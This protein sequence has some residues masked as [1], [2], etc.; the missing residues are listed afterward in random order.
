MAKKLR[1][2]SDPALAKPHEAGAVV[3]LTQTLLH[4][5]FGA[6]HYLSPKMHPYHLKEANI[7]FEKLES[8]QEKILAL[9]ILPGN[10]RMISDM[11]FLGEIHRYGFNLVV[12]TYLAFDHFLL[13]ILM[14]AYQ[15]NP[16]ARK[17]WNDRDMLGRVNHVIKRVLDKKELFQSK[18]Y[19]G[20][21]DIEQRRHAFNHPTARRV[22]NG[23]LGAWDEVPLAWIISG[24]YKDP[25]LGAMKLFEE[26]HALWEAEKGKYDRPGTLTV[27]RGIKSLHPAQPANKNH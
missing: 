10:A 7:A 22:Y 26:L 3:E 1:L 14:V 13:E 8:F 2:V 12:H 9:P 6:I 24:K 20:L 16:D 25:Y 27:E 5:Q 17:L 11:D 18:E 23:D 19:A 15:N 21:A 4:V